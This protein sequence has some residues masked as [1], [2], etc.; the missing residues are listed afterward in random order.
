V[1]EN[2]NESYQIVLIPI[3][4]DLLALHGD[5]EENKQLKTKSVSEQ[6][7]KRESYNGLLCPSPGPSP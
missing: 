6:C 1:Q 3:L 2:E 5:S 4:F 7:A